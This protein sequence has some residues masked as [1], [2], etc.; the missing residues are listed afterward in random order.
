MGI[1]IAVRIYHNSKCATS[2]K[3][4]ELLRSSGVEP[5]IVDYLKEPPSEAEWREVLSKLE[6]PPESM[7]RKKEP[8]YAELGLAGKQ[9]SVDRVARLLAEHP[10]LLER[11]VVVRGGKA[12]VARPPEKAEMVLD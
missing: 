4:L 5:D 3:V 12:I 1:G 10:R 9:L 6:G 11:P 2:R 8:L 7:L